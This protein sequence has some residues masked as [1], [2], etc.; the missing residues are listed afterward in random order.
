[1]RKYIS[2]LLALLLTSSVC[3]TAANTKVVA[4]GKIVS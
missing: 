3:A 4:S 1:M 2:L